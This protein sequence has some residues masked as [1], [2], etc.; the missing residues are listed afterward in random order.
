MD[1]AKKQD[2]LSSE[3]L[4]FN[5]RGSGPPLLLVHG[6]M[7]TGEMFEPITGQLASHHHLIIP[8]LRGHGQSRKLPPPYTPTQMASDL[9]RLLD[10]LSIESAAVL[11]D[12][13]GGAIAQ[14]FALDYPKRCNRLVLASTYTYN[15][16]TFGDKVV[17][18]LIPFV[19]RVLGMR[20]FAKLA[21]TL[22]TRQLSKERADRLAG[23]VAGQDLKL[24]LPALRETVIKFDSRRRLSEIKCPT[25]IVAGSIDHGD[26]RQAKMLNDGITGS[27]LIIMDNADHALLW[28]HTDEFMRIV[29]EFLKG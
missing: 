23:I 12:S 20:R 9:A 26:I 14:Q 27:K 5:E 25:L 19:V 22:G 6:L 3:S 10:N 24:M 21:L 13:M 15:F 28:G 16:V 8:D 4:Y 17:G 1:S 29:E 11:G 7:A 2:L 18:R